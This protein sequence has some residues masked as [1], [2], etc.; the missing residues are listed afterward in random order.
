MVVQNFT[1][2][3]TLTTRRK[4]GEQK[5]AFSKRKLQHLSLS[6]RRGFA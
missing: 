4:D 5:S 2:E 6:T 1:S 3:L